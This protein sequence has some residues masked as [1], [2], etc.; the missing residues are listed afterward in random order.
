M[1]MRASS[2]RQSLEVNRGGGYVDNG[3]AAITALPRSSDP[4]AFLRTVERAAVSVLW[5]TGCVLGCVWFLP[6]TVRYPQ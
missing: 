5:A 6:A 2:V 4:K 3:G 1:R